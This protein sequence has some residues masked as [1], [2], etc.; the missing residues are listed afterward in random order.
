MGVKWTQ[1]QI[2]FV[3]HNYA[4]MTDAE[5]AEKIGRPKGSVSWR[6]RELRLARTNQP[7]ESTI[8]FDCKN[9]CGGCSWSRSFRPVPG[10]KAEETSLF[11]GKDKERTKSYRVISCPEFD[12]GEGAKKAAEEP[13]PAPEKP[14]LLE[15]PCE[16]CFSR[17]ACDSMRGSCAEWRRWVRHAW[18][19]VTKNFGREERAV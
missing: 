1:E 10:W 5:L 13:P 2:E 12:G 3:M 18:K 15:S 19:D 11:A 8:C 9:A 16:K 7:K 6:L 17:T 4:T 14:R